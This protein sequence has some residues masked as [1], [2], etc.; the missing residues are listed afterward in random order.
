MRGFGASSATSSAVVATAP[1]VAEMPANNAAASRKVERS[2]TSAGTTPTSESSRP[3]T[4]APVAIAVLSNTPFS[5]LAAG[6]SASGTRCWDERGD[7]DLRD[8]GEHAADRDRHVDE[9]RRAAEQAG[10][11]GGER[12]GSQQ[13][14][15]HEQPLAADAVDD[16]GGDAAAKDRR[17]EADEHQEG[18]AARGPRLLIHP[19]HE[20]AD[21]EPVAGLRDQA[22]EQKP[23][24]GAAA[25]WIE[26][27]PDCRDGGGPPCRDARI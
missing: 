14:D 12:D 22:A 8:R 7:G 19:A 11:D 13:L 23:P 21:G 25:E 17:R 10:D 27:P 3:P 26:E 24:H 20:R 6:S 4:I 18:D 2:A 9:D 16:R 1:V 5:P 15:G